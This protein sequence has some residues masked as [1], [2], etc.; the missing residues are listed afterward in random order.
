MLEAN[1][2]QNEVFAGNW[3][4]ELEEYDD[5]LMA[6]GFSS[7]DSKQLLFL[8]LFVGSYFD[9]PGVLDKV[10]VEGIFLWSKC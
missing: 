6:G 4:V 7:F 10:L 5:E 8:A 1:L 2:G 9:H 3:R